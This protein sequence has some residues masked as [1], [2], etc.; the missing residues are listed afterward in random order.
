MKSH[1]F[2]TSLLTAYMFFNASAVLANKAGV[3]QFG[4]HGYIEYIPGN[5]PIVLSAPHGGPIGDDVTGAPLTV[6]NI[7]DRDCTNQEFAGNSCRTTNDYNTAVLTQAIVDSFAEKTG[8]YP[9][10][11][12]NQLARRKLDA[13]REIGEAAMGD[14][15]AKTAWHEYHD[16]IRVAKSKIQQDYGSGLLLDVHG[17]GHSQR[18]IQVGYLLDEND[19]VLSDSELNS[20]N[21]INKSSI[22][23]LVSNN[24]QG[25]SHSALIRGRQAFGTMLEDLNMHSIPSQQSP[26]PYTDISFFEGGYNLAIHSSRNGGTID[27]IQVELN[28]TDRLNSGG[29]VLTSADRIT[30]ALILYIDRHYN[31]RFIGNYCELL[32][33]GSILDYMPAILAPINQK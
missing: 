12:I 21:L 3:S 19:L 22:K 13:N 1:Q 27:G 26:E 6:T 20:A 10:A 25:F 8:C 11:V 23:S 24:R 30:D 5:L 32:K 16:F 7:I 9:H 28:R 31:N 33:E 2:F 17:H 29:N 15:S 18:H 4:E 14:E